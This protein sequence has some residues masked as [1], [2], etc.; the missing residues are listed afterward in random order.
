MLTVSSREGPC[1]RYASPTRT[2]GSFSARLAAMRSNGRDHSGS[3]EPW[4][5]RTIPS[6]NAAA[7]MQRCA[8]AFVDA[9]QQPQ[10]AE[11]DGAMRQRV[12]EILDDVERDGHV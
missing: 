10:R 3:R 7:S 9:L 11:A 12:A 8:A 5:T 2:A 1:S 6:F 4:A